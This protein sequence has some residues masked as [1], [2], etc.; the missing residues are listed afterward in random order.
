MDATTFQA[1]AEKYERLMFQISWSML[2]NSEDCADAVQ[3]ALIKAWQKR[4]TLHDEERFKP[5]LMR[6][7][8]NTCKDML[9]RRKKVR[10]VS[11]EEQTLTVQ[12]PEVPMPVNEAIE[13]L[14]PEYRVLITLYYLG[15]F[16]MKDLAS[17]FSF[18][19]RRGGAYAVETGKGLP[20]RCSRY[21][22][23]GMGKHPTCRTGDAGGGF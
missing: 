1:E 23:D 12:P 13:R 20:S 15:G 11:Y 21:T 7:L 14:Q 2:R 4:D 18:H 8:H 22:D 6:I 19:Y 17:M 3:D 10:F 5:W 16:D 9:R